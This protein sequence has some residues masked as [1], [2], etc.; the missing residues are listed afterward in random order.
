MSEWKLDGSHMSDL[1]GNVLISSFEK[2]RAWGLHGRV[3][4]LVCGF[5]FVH[6]NVL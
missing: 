3:L 5:G 2:D 6:R 1:H 4:C